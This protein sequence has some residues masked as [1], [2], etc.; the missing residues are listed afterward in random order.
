MALR[1]GATLVGSLFAVLGVLGFSFK[2]ILIKLAYAWYPVD[3]VTLLALRMLYSVP[4]FVAMAW[5]ASR[6]PDTR[7]FTRGDWVSLAALGCIGYYLASLLDFMGLAY[8]TA[9]LERL[10]LFLYPTVVVIL[11]ALM[12]GQRITRRALIALLLSY[13]GIALVFVRDLQGATDQA[14]LWIGGILV[15]ASAVLYAAFLVGSV[16]AIARLGSMRFTSWAMLAS[17][18]FVLVHFAATRDLSALSVSAPIHA[19]S[20]AMAILSTVLPTWL[21]AESI[22]RVGANASSLIGTLGPVFTIGLGAVILGEPVYGIQ[23]AGAALVLVGVVV[24]TLPPRRDQR[25]AGPPDETAV[26]KV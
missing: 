11:S 22:H 4:F 6:A 1:R 20:L 23:L 17:T 2:A 9:S 25:P 15:F 19:L 24:V 21:I 26:D 18:V 10:I 8:I 3:A 14:A 7:P 5:W 13:A 16:D 12:L